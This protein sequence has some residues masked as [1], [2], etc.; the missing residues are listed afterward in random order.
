M[1][2]NETSLVI[3]TGNQGLLD[4][5]RVS[6]GGELKSFLNFDSLDDGFLNDL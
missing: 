4:R 3:G 6:D 2:S 5:E 1:S